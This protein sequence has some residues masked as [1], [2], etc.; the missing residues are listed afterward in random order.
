MSRNDKPLTLLQ[1]FMATFI[2][3]LS[4]EYAGKKILGLNAGLSSAF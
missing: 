2:S 1:L 4:V 3:N